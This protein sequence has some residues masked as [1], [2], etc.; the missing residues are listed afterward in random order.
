MT[1]PRLIF[2]PWLILLSGLGLTWLVWDHERQTTTKELHSQ[3]D[4]ALRD[5]VSRIEQ[6]VSNYEQLL[7]GVQGLLATTALTDRK[8]VH[9]YVE[10][11]QQDA[12]FSGV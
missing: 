9:D 3:F 2:L 12:N 6:R 4:F 5:T 11:I 8:A 7:R 1:A 10:T